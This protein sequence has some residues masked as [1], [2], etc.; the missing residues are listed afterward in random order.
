MTIALNIRIREACLA[1]TTGWNVGDGARRAG[2]SQSQ[3]GGYRRDKGYCSRA[4]QERICTALMLP[5]GALLWDAAA[6]LAWP[7]SQQPPHQ[8]Q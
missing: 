2:M 3:W 8:Q 7:T 4:M 1:G 6:V 5:P